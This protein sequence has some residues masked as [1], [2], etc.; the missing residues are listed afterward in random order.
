MPRRTVRC[1]DV[2]QQGGKIYVRFSDKTEYEFQSRADI[3]RWIAERLTDDVVK[4][5]LLAFILEDSANGTL[6]TDCD[7][8]RIT[9]DWLAPTKLVVEAAL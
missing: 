5:M 8:K 7:G 4:A 1:R 2:R 9:L 6:L 3:R